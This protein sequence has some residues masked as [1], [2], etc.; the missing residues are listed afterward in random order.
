M[1]WYS[2][3]TYVKHLNDIKLYNKGIGRYFEWVPK[4]AA[5]FN[6]EYA[7][8]GILDYNDLIQAGHVGLVEAWVNIDWEKIASSPEPDAKLWKFLKIRI[9]GEMRREI[10][11]Y[12]SH[13]ALPINLQ[14][15]RRKTRDWYDKALVTLFPTFFDT[16]FPDLIDETTPWDQIQMYDLLDDIM[17]D[18]LTV[19]ERIILEKFYGLD[20][21]DRWS[22]KRIAEY[23]NVT[24][25]SIENKKLRAIQKLKKNDDVLKKISNF[26][27][28]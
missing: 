11:K 17:A 13:I 16:A 27:S 18:H 28:S 3:P 21:N 8:I 14:E 10:D 19:E 9:K 12:S 5:R 26:L 4:L 25:R 22:A 6:R 23:N 15:Q 7:N 20:G 2:H 1:K 24:I